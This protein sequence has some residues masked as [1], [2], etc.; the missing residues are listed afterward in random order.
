MAL[1]TAQFGYLRSL[2]YTPAEAGRQ[3]KFTVSWYHLKRGNATPAAAILVLFDI[4]FSCITC[5]VSLNP[6]F[7]NGCDKSM[8]E[9]NGAH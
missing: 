6:I 4:I 5:L 7:A 8:I 1:V 9:H 3:P 2:I